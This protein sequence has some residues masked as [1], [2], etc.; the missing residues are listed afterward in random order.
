MNRESW[1]ADGLL[2][3]AAMIWGFSFVAQRA[4]MAHTGPFTFNA[5]RFALGALTVLPFLR[6]G[7]REA[8]PLP[9][10]SLLR[11]GAAAGT[12]LFL[13]VSLQQT[14]IVSTTAGKA[15]FITGLYVV[16]VP[17]LGLFLGRRA[18][19][20]TWVGGLLAVAGFYL[21]SVRSGLRLAPGDG[22]V[23]AGALFWA[24]HVLIVD[25]VV[26]RTCALRLAFQQFVLCA[27]LSAAAALAFEKVETAGIRAAALPIFYGGV[28]SVG[29]AFTLQVVA[30]RSATPAHA[31]LLLSLE[32]VFDTI[33]ETLAQGEKIKISGFG[34]FNVRDKNPRRGRNP[35]TKQDLQLRARKVV[36]FKTSGVLRRKINAGLDD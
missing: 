20:G 6:A 19:R 5:V 13:A 11:A 16:I 14:G 26:R 21:L 3:L 27:V 25:R 7:R 12:A 18:G 32:T 24:V 35:Q 10:P 30:Q 2:L 17:L 1:R 28:L 33:K 15:G 31:A 22:L 4:G 8:P 9:A 29:V 36:V 34:S 23:L